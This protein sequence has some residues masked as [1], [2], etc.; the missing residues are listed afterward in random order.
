MVAM[1]GGR[2]LVA[3][4]VGISRVTL[5]VHI[6]HDGGHR[7]ERSVVTPDP[8]AYSSLVPLGEL[9][10]PTVAEEAPWDVGLLFET[11]PKRLGEGGRPLSPAA[12]NSQKEELHF[13]RL[14]IP[15]ADGQGTSAARDE[16]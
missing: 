13:G 12:H 15:P 2:T 11:K 14:T 5:F 7:W 3:T 8:S 4:T 9:A 1:H 6:S 10:P 16:L